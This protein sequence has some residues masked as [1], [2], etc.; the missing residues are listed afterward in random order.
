[1]TNSRL[2]SLFLLRARGI[3]DNPTTPINIKRLPGVLECFNRY[4]DLPFNFI[5]EAGILQLFR[6]AYHDGIAKELCDRETVS[7]CY[8][9]YTGTVHYLTAQ[10]APEEFPSYNGAKD[11]I[12][13]NDWTRRSV[14]E[15]P[16]VLFRF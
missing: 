7:N 1:M 8:N 11:E 16:F 4:P 15:P 3:V 12:K 13:T 2:D 6:K 9:R 10:V 5:I 14:G